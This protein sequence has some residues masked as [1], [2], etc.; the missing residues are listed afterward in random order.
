MHARVQG[1]D[2][3]V[4]ALGEPG[5]VLDRGHRN[6]L[7]RNGLRRRT[8][9]HD[10]HAGRVQGVHQLREAGLVVHGDERPADRAAR[11]RGVGRTHGMVTFRSVTVNPSRTMRPTRST[12]LRTLR[13]LDPLGQ[14]VDCVAVLDRYGDLPDD[15][16]GVD[17]LVD[18]EQGGPGDL[19]PVGQRVAWAV[20]AGERRQQGVV[21]VDVPAGKAPQERRTDE[22]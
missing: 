10:R 19:H 12:S 1:L 21:A 14:D 11:V 15:D 22:P 13:L 9:R 20:D 2:A 4:E 3:T 16:T 7:R 18:D 6:S 8:G 17:A 5:E